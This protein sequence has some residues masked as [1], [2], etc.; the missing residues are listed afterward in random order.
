MLAKTISCAVIGLDGYIVQVEVDISAGLPSFTVVGLADTAVQEARERVRAAIRNSG[1]SFP[2]KRITVNLAPAHLK[3][4]GPVY[5]LPIAIAILI[6]SGQLYA[7][8]SRSLFLGELSLDGSLRHANGIL[9]MISVAKENNILDIFVPSEDAEEAALIKGINIYACNS[10][11]QIANHLLGNVKLP[12]H[13]S[14]MTTTNCKHS[15]DYVDMSS[16][17]GQEHAKRAIEIAAAGGHN[18]LMSGPPGSGKTMLAR[19]LPSI[20]P[21]MSLSQAI[22][23]TKIYSICGLLPRNT[24]LITQRPFR[25]PHYTISHAGLVG[26]GN[27]P[28]PGEISLSHNGVLFMDEFPEYN[29]ISLESLR[30]PIEDKTVTISRAHGSITY[31]ANF[32]LV[33]AMNPC[34]CGYYGDSLKECQCSSSEITRYHKRISG[35][36]LDRIDIFVEVPRV[37]YEKLINDNQCESSNIVRQRINQALAI[38]SK[39]FIDNTASKNSDMNSVDVKRFCQAEPAAMSLLR[40]AMRQINF[41]ARSFHRILKLSRTISDLDCSE[42]IRANHIAEALQYR[43]RTWI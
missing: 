13:D 34:P 9:S 23:T 16:I 26:G 18:I 10:I 35:P 37:E 3:K 41:T 28:R 11:A 21:A 17:K 40:A 42:I 33:A 2:M 24:P 38:Q 15:S 25:S 20:L 39:R 19:S 8:V 12:V 22:E 32:M 43:Q 29:R 7:D 4:A 14:N 6:S 31:P 27:M 36:L 1:Y 5:D 30:Q